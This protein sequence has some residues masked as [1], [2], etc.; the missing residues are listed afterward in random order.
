MYMNITIHTPRQLVAAIP[1][2]IGFHP[3]SS[4]VIVVLDGSEVCTIT[5]FDW[6]ASPVDLP[7]NI[8]TGLSGA[9]EPAIVLVAYTEQ[10]ISLEETVHLVKG[11]EDSDL[12]D[13]LWVRGG[14]WISLMCEDESCCPAEGHPL[15]D[16]SPADVAF[17][18]AGSAPFESRDDLVQRLGAQQLA[19]DAIAKRQQAQT[20]VDAEVSKKLKIS[21]KDFDQRKAKGQSSGS[22][23]QQVSKSDI[24]ASILK[25]VATFLRADSELSWQEH[26]WLSAVVSD[27][28]MRDGL[29]RLLFDDTLLRAPARAKL[30]NAVSRAADVHVPALAT[31]LAGCAWL[32]G[33][34]A[35]ASVAL[36]RA[37]DADPAYSLAR[38]LD[39]A[40]AH[41]VPPS[42][43]SDS[44]EAV[45]YD[46][47]LAG[48]A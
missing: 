11:C 43:W 35:L 42:V 30:I 20:E 40:I 5:R 12:L 26:A 31:V 18:V 3:E 21:D 48:A 46:E 44:L 23:A 38:L 24:R 37:L 8:R 39:R 4:L 17:V 45:S 47:C 2:L 15:A 28:R 36:E 19:N 9:S 13:V 34:G 16:I 14:C 33:N 41:N 25:E 1:H 22:N 29:L 27:I 7:I 10:I 32:D 6:P